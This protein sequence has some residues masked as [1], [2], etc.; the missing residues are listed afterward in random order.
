MNLKAQVGFLFGQ[1]N[2]QRQRHSKTSASN[3]V[4]KQRQDAINA[5]A[6][7]NEQAIALSPSQVRNTH[8][9]TRPFALRTMNEPDFGL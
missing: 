9:Q 3:Y 2:N 8:A 6:K 4:R 1:Q 5:A 7:A